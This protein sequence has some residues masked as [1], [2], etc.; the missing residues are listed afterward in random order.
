MRLSVLLSCSAFAISGLLA[1]SSTAQ[2]P[3]PQPPPPPPPGEIYDQPRLPREV[4][5]TVVL[6][7]EAPATPAPV[8]QSTARS[9]VPT[10]DAPQAEP[11]PGC[12]GIGCPPTE[13][14]LAQ[15]LLSQGPDTSEIYSAFESRAHQFA[16]VGFVKSGWPVSIEYQAEPGTVTVLRIKL[17]HQRKILIFPIPF[18]EVAFQANLDALDS[19][20]AGDNPWHRTVTIPAI[21]LSREADAAADDGLHVARYE[22]RS[23]RI[24]EGQGRQRAPLNVIGMTVGPQVVGSL[25]LL[26]DQFEGEQ[27]QIPASDAP[28]TVF[29][30]RYRAQRSYDLLKERIE[31]Y[32]YNALDY[33]VARVIG[34]GHSASE[35]QLFQVNW[36]LRRNLRPGRY[37]A[38]IVGWWRCSGG[39]SVVNGVLACPNDPNWAV[40]SSRDVNLYY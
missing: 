15:Q 34:S 13:V 19:E 14:A 39:V 18:F 26:A 25:T 6:P 20:R 1:S 10:D 36:R 9:H 32:N 28:P 8:P 30:F 27:R 29:P 23:Y 11:P 31:R 22:V 5:E 4:Y 24:V 3:P 12:G 37:R 2:N 21:H 7:S 33:Q 40:T 35:G 16:V 17:Y 38:S